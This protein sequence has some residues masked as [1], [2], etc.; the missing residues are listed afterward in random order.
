M[1]LQTKPQAA[2][3]GAVT[4]AQLTVPVA[5]HLRSAL[6]QCEWL[7][8]LTKSPKLGRSRGC[9]SRLGVLLRLSILEHAGRLQG[10]PEVKVYSTSFDR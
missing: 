6:I 9:T 1:P 2:T 10:R 7:V 5:P 3:F 8:K 4:A